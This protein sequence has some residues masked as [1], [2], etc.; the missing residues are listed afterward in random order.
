MQ[1]ASPEEDAAYTCPEQTLGHYYH[2]PTRFSSLVDTQS[3]QVLNSVPVVCCN[4]DEYDIPFRIRPGYL[5]E[6]RGLLTHGAGKPHILGLRDFN[7]D[8]KV[9]E[10]AFYVK[11]SCNEPL[12]MVLG[13]SQRQD[14]VI[15]YEFLIHSNVPG[16]SDSQLWM[17]GF[18]SRKPIE[19]LHWRYEDLLNSGRRLKY[20]FR[21][22]P[23][24]ERFEGTVLITDP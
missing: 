22:F 5:Y 11:E 9:L 17:Y 18:T 15:T 24:C 20:D 1:D 7:G 2:A 3:K 23:E 16:E 10:F 19:P 6:V 12:T 14:R 21:Y 8:G 4:A 13:Y